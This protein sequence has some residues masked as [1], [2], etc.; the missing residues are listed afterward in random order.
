MK[1]IVGTVAVV[2]F[3]LCVSATPQEQEKKPTETIELNLA[4]N[5]RGLLKF[6]NNKGDPCEVDAEIATNGADP[7]QDVTITAKRK[8]GKKEWFTCW[9]E[10]PEVTLSRIP[11]SI[12]FLGEVKDGTP[13]IVIDAADPNGPC[14]AM[15]FMQIGKWRGDKGHLKVHG[16]K[17][18]VWKENREREV[19]APLRL[20]YMLIFSQSGAP[21]TVKIKG[22]RIYL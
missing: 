5:L 9:V 12:E 17:F 4:A 10:F 14:I 7:V 2:A 8:D 20:K 19:E 6:T 1:R 15:A 21:F 3:A 11:E 13:N 22:I 18:M 16:N